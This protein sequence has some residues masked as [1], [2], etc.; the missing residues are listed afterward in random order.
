MYCGYRVRDGRPPSVQFQRSAGRILRR[1][2]IPVC[3]SPIP[4]VGKDRLLQRLQPA[5]EQDC[6][7]MPVPSARDRRTRPDRFGRSNRRGSRCQSATCLAAALRLLNS[8]T[9]AQR[10]IN[11]AGP[12]GLFHS[13]RKRMIRLAG[14]SRFSVVSRVYLL[15][16]PIAYSRHAPRR[17]KHVRLASCA[18]GCS[19]LRT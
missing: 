4:K 7:G 16:L 14:N 1:R 15:I 5:I 2:S 8:L 10:E 9:Q 17:T 11:G 13:D 6:N 18:Q 3:P 12:K 19:R